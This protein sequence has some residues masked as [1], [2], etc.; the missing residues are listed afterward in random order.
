MRRFLKNFLQALARSTDQGRVE[1]L[2]LE[3]EASSRWMERNRE[4]R[5]LGCRCGQ[6]AAHVTYHG[7]NLGVVPVEFWTCAKHVGVNA[8]T[9]PPGAMWPLELDGLDGK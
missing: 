7:G 4:E 8:W 6:P 2:T 1:Q 9:G 5:A 3:L